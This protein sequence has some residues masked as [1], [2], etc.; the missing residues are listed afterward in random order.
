MQQRKESA[1]KEAPEEKL[2]E[3]L[4]RV[5]AL[6]KGGAANV[7]LAREGEIDLAVKE[8]FPEAEESFKRELEF[9]LKLREVRDDPRASM[10]V[11]Y[12]GVKKGKRRMIAYEVG[13]Q[14]LSRVLFSLAGE[15]QNGE[16]IYRITPL[17]SYQVM[18]R[19]AVFKEFIRRMAAALS[20]LQELGLCHNDI[21]PEN[22]LLEEARLPAVSLKI[23]DYGSVG[24]R[25]SGMMTPEYMPPEALRG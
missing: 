18:L 24:D 22:I 25:S 19:P 2:G 23:C 1:R 10:F 4:V 8:F 21:K 14:A 17:A 13:G 3:G 15:F 6:G 11:E 16:R 9:G 20:L 7:W 5:R 12:R